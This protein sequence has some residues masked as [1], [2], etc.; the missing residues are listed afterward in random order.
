MWKR[1]QW[2]VAVSVRVSVFDG[3]DETAMIREGPMQTR[4]RTFANMEHRETARED[5]NYGVAG[6]IYLCDLGMPQLSERDGER[7]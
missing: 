3:G 2:Q 4:Y 1:V 5:S 6:L 7:E